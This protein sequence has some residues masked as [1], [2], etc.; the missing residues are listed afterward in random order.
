MSGNDKRTDDKKKDGP[1]V[2]TVAGDFVLG[3]V[4]HKNANGTTTVSPGPQVHTQR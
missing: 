3:K 1:T 4:I 2:A